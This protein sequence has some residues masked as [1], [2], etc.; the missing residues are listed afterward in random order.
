MANQVEWTSKHKARVT[1]YL[2]KDDNSQL[3][4]TNYQVLK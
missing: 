4:V 2:S 1:E 3:A